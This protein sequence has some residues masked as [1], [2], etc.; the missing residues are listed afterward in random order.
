MLWL[1]KRMRE[2]ECRKCDKSGLGAAGAVPRQRRFS[3]LEFLTFQEL[4][5]FKLLQGFYALV[6]LVMNKILHGTN[7]L[8]RMF[9]S[10]QV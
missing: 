10:T 7:L 6:H 8:L 9:Q 1:E 3:Q 4:A 2:C 5:G